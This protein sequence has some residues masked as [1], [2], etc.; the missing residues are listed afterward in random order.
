MLIISIPLLIGAIMAFMQV[1]VAVAVVVIHA[2]RRVLDLAG[3]VL[4][5]KRLLVASNLTVRHPQIEVEIWVHGEAFTA[6]GEYSDFVQ[7]TERI[8]QIMRR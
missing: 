5:R 6:I 2:Q 1:D 8:M 3:A 4:V 7:I